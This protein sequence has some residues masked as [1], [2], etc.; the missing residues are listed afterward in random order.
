MI[1]LLNLGEND[2]DL[3]ITFFF[4]GGRYNL[5]AH[6][7]VNGSTMLNVSDVIMM[8]QPDS[9]RNTIPPDVTHGSAVLSGL[10]GYPELINVAVSVGIFNVSTA[11]C[12]TTCPT[13]FGYTAFQVQG[14]NSTA[15]VG[16]TATFTALALG[17]DNYWHDVSALPPYPDGTP[18]TVW[19]SDNGNVATSQGA[20]NFNGVST[21]TFNAVA[22][23]NWMDVNPD[24][25]AGSHQQCPTTPY[26][27]NS[28]GGTIYQ[29]IPTSLSIVGTDSTTS[30]SGCTTSGGNAGCGVSRTFTYQ[31]NDQNRRPMAVANMPVGDVIC[32]TSTNQLNL[33]GYNTTCGGTTGSCFGTAGPCGKFTDQNGQFPENLTVCAPACK[34]SGTCTTAGQTIANQTWTVNGYTLSSDVKGISYQ[35]NKILVNGQ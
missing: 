20:G 22:T 3:S 33:Q 8:Q 28:A 30:E 23:T 2:Q 34:P 1:S 4:D 21:G 10:L 7:K 5:P 6:L 13:C 25:P 17:Q 9:D 35:C 11:T 27:P 31:V 18:G 29:P 14:S 15:P 24:C 16:G 19:T 32:N 26:G 12:G